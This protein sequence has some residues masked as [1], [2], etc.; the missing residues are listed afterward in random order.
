M[1][2]RARIIFLLLTFYVFLQFIWWAFQLIQL[3][4]TLDNSSENQKRIIAMIVGEGSVFILILAVG[5][6][7]IKKA[8]QKEIELSNRQS[9][10]LLSITHELKTPIAANKL[11]FQ[12][13]LKRDLDADTKTNLINN[14]L[15]ESVRLETLIDN[16]LN[17]SRIDNKV[18]EPAF[19]LENLNILINNLVENSKKLHQERNIQLLMDDN[20]ELKIDKYMIYMVLNNILENA[21]KYSDIKSPI[22]IHVTKNLKYINIDFKDLGIGIKKSESDLIFEKFYRAGNEHTRVQNGSGLGLYLSL[23]F[24]KM[25]GGSINHRKNHPVGSVFTVKLPYE[26]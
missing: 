12:T 8:I 10:F 20:Y 23:E 25:H 2:R 1:N 26:S 15:V 5:L 22:E 7:Q 19:E 11:A 13:L 3:N 6:W 24:I 18:M 9:N 16:L 14:A 17:A 21:I 4:I